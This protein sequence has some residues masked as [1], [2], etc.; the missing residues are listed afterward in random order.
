MS[1][2]S[3][4]LELELVLALMSEG[5]SLRIWVARLITMNSP[6][7]CRWYNFLI[8][9]STS[10]YRSSILELMSPAVL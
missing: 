6:V 2:R 7:D 1:I 3:N 9:M 5:I 4:T 10:N 8:S